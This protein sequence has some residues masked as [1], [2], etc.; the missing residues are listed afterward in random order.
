MHSSLLQEEQPFPSPH[1]A[2]PQPGLS[3]PAPS[4]RVPA[5]L[6]AAGLEDRGGGLQEGEGFSCS[7]SWVHPVCGVEK[8]LDP[9]AVTSLVLSLHGGLLLCTVALGSAVPGVFWTR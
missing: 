6:L 7:P 2:G 8:A 9:A 3:Q 4:G 1:H 5:L